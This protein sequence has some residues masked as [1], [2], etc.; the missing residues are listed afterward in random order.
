VDA[1]DGPHRKEPASTKKLRQGDA[2]WETRKLVLGRIID[3]I[4]MTLELPP[5]HKERL[6]AI[7]GEIPST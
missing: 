5:H 7:L 2:F 6:L 3:T 4:C 1:L